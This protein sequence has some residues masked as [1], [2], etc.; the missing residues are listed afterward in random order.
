MP[1]AKVRPA[2]SCQLLC[3]NPT[4]NRRVPPSSSTGAHDVLVDYLHGVPLAGPGKAKRT[5]AAGWPLL[6]RD[7]NPG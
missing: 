5:L 1:L 7:E 6:A 3:G 2:I 4:S